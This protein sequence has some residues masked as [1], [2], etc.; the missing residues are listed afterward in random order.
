MNWISTRGVVLDC[1]P[2]LE[3]LERE[4]KRQAKERHERELE[5]H[6]RRLGMEYPQEDNLPQGNN[7]PPREQVHG[8]WLQQK[9]P[10]K[11]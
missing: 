3:K 1:V 11:F 7:A 9:A 2:E 6:L 4:N 5:E 8:V 10:P